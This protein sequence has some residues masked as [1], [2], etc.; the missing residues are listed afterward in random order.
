MKFLFYFFI[1]FLAACS[2]HR[3]AVE[4][5]EVTLYLRVE[6]ARDVKFACSLDQFRLKKA[7]RVD[8]DTWKIRVPGKHAFTYFFLVNGDYYI[9]DCRL[10]E[11]DDFGSENCIYVPAM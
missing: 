1:F 8:T 7:V 3:Y 6:N 4:H 11:R 5:H 10:K 9:P 2:V